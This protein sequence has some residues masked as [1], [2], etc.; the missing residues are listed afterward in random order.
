M[1]RFKET[2]DRG[3]IQNTCGAGPAPGETRGALTFKLDDIPY[4]ASY[5]TLFDEY[6]INWVNVHFTALQNVNQAQ[7]ANIITTNPMWTAIDFNDGSTGTPVLDIKLYSN[8]KA[9]DITKSFNVFFRPKVLQMIYQS[10]IATSYQSVH[11]G[12]IPTTDAAVPHYCLKYACE[13]IAQTAGI[14]DLFRID[15]SYGLQFR[16]QK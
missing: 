6:R 13:P 5:Q 8:A 1:Y 2:I 9:H 14:T 11:S 16:S 4:Y 7:V 3:L 10:A 12:W 15:V